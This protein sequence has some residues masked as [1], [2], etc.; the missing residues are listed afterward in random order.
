[1]YTCYYLDYNIYDKGDDD[2]PGI[3]HHLLIGSVGD[4]EE[5][6]G[7]LVP[8]LAKIDLGHPVGVQR[9]TLVGVDDDNEETLE[10]FPIIKHSKVYDFYLPSRCG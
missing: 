7:D 4:G 8:P 9:V 3:D 6:W 1:M 5:M 2:L 10:L